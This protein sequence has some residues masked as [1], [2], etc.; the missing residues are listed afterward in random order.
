MRL[1]TKFLFAVAVLA[2][3][4]EVLAAVWL[5]AP[6]VAG[7]ILA[8]VFAVGL[9]GCAWALWTRDS[10]VA[11]SVIGVLLLIDVAGTPFYE[12][13]SALDWVVQLAF[14]AVGIVGLVAWFDVLRHH[15][16]ERRARRAAAVPAA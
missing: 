1:S 9:L 16:R 5:N 15:V 3:T 2:G 6:E 8:G 14:A 4:F 13:A 10:I 7:Q 12:K 11:A